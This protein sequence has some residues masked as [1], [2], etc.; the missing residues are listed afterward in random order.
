M[1]YVDKSRLAS[2]FGFSFSSLL[3]CGG[4]DSCELEEMRKIVYGMV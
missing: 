4:K 3:E 1:E 2:Y